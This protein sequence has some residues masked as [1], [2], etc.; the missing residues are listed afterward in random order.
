MEKYLAFERRLHGGFQKIYF[1]KNGFG[2]SVVKTG[3]KPGLDVAILKG[4][5]KR[6]SIVD[7]PG[8]CL[9]N[10]ELENLLNEIKSYQRV[11]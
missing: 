1:F 5:I 11:V 3:D 10:K 6:Y 9:T 2:A 7:T 8:Y 4:N